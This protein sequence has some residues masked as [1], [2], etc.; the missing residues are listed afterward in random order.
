MIICNLFYKINQT[1]LE[2]SRPIINNDGLHELDIPEEDGHNY[3]GLGGLDSEAVI[4][5][6]WNAILVLDQTFYRI[7]NLVFAF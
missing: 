2:T 5:M 6:R 7:I 4:L 1:N 3:S